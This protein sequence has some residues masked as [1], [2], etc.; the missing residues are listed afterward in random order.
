L[1]AT[2]FARLR[3]A[4]PLA[5]FFLITRRLV[6]REPFA[7]ARRPGLVLELEIRERLTVSVATMNNASVSQ[8]AGSSRGILPDD[9]PTLGRSRDTPP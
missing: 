4:R 2:L 8:A 3:F 6:A 7:A 1:G 5:K 9:T